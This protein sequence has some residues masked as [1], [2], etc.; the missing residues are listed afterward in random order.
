MARPSSIDRLPKEIREAIGSARQRGCTLDEILA[1]IRE[2]GADVSRSA[3]G[4]HLKGFD[5]DAE[6]MRQSRVTAEALTA[7]FGDEPDHQVARMNFE[8]MHS[9]IFE[10]Q[11][12]TA[13]SEDEEGNPVT[14][15]AKQVKFLAGAMKD[16][17]SAQKVDT[18]RVLKLRAEFAKEAAAKVDTI[19]KA[20]GL[21]A[22]TV[23][24]LRHAVLGG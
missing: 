1:K 10:L 5:Q 14:L 8:L 24:A 17:A 19:G 11:M 16:I 7:K 2:M 6:R 21:S 15:D 23:A 9:M 13:S 3:V 20:K 4:R 18:D 22:D 12:A